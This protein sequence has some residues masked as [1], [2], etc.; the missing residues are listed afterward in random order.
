[1][2]LY[3]IDAALMAAYENA[4]DMETGEI[5]DNEA[6]AAIDGLEMALAEKTE[7]ILLWIKN[8]SAEAEA[9]KTE[10]MSFDARQKRAERKAESLKRYVSKVLEGKK[11]KTDHVEASWRKSESVEFD[12]NVMSLPENCIRVKE[13]EVNKTELKKLLKAGQEIEGAW[14]VEKQN[15]Q[16]K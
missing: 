12:G 2:N 6:Y 10:K 13:P 5:L 9:L 1:M 3:E 8:L 16:I 11:F 7:N 4:V 15:L 14:L